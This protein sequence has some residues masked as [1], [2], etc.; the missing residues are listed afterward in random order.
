MSSRRALLT[1]TDLRR[2]AQVVREEGVTLKGRVDPLGGLSFSIAPAGE[3]AN[4]DGD[5]LDDRLEAFGSR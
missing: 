5:D 2:M 1:V 4:D 3:R